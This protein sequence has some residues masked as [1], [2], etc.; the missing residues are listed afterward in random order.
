MKTEEYHRIEEKIRIVDGSPKLVYIVD[1]RTDYQFSTYYD[2]ERYI[3]LLTGYYG[4][5]ENRKPKTWWFTR[6]GEYSHAD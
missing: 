3:R 2:A 6:F 5:N 4:A 1:G